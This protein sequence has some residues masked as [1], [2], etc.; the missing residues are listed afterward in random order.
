MR[1]KPPTY[2]RKT[3]WSTYLRQFEAAA[4][5]NKWTEEEEAT[6]MMISLR[7]NAANILQVIPEMQQ[8]DFKYLVSR[9]EMRYG[10]S[11][12]QQVS[13]QEPPKKARGDVARI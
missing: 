11:H 7:G 10:N 13:A 3:P 9:L 5:I 1:T 8:I 6:A 2:D 12:L 4:N